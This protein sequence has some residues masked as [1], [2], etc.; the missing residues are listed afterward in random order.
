[1]IMYRT[2]EANNEMV[3]GSVSRIA[4]FTRVVP[5]DCRLTSDTFP[6]ECSARQSASS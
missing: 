4:M 3:A 2:G 5:A 6:C 1:M